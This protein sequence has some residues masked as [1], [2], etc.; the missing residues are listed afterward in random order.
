MYKRYFRIDVEAYTQY[1]TYVTNPQ[2]FL[3]KELIL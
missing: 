1:Q 3:M 2:L